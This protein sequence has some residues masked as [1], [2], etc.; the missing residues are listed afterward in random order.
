[1]SVIAEARLVRIHIDRVAFQS[2]NP[3]RERRSTPLPIGE[4]QKLYREVEGDGEDESIPGDESLIHLTQDEHFYSQ[5]VFG[6]PV[7]GDDH[8]VDTSETIY[9]R[10]VDLY[11]GSGGKPSN[12][13]LVKSHMALSKSERNLAARSKSEGERWHALSG[14][15]NWQI[16]TPSSR[17]LRKRGI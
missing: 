15:R 11:L 4:P 3:L 12:E 9:D 13:Y 14:C 2:P 16:I 6:I 8:E 1:M 7:N 17:I 5:K 10:V